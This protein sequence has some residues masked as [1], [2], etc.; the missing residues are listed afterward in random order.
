MAYSTRVP[1]RRLRRS[2]AAMVAI[3]ATAIA[4]CSSSHS[5]KVTLTHPAP[6]H[7]SPGAA[8]TGFFTNIVGSAAQACTYAAVGATPTCLLELNQLTATVSNLAIGAV[9]VRGTQALVTVLGT[10]CVTPLGGSKTCSSNTN[11]RTGQPAGGSQAEFSR[12]YT[13]ATQGSSAL[14]KSA[15]PC[16]LVR[17]QW[18]V[19]LST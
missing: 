16:E 1:E 19:S 8:V 14:D 2:M 15:I 9:T 11:P 6:G 17:T 13:A 3:A 18:Y 7:G 5:P 10:F 12:K 4:G